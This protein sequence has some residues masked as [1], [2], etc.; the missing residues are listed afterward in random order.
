MLTEAEILAE[1]I[2]PDRGDISPTVACEILGLRF[3]TETTL[4]IRELLASNNAGTITPG[5]RSDLEKYLRVSQFIDLL[6]A[7]PRLSLDW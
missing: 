3:R 7:K 2:Q 1:V 4:R 6:Q 5:E